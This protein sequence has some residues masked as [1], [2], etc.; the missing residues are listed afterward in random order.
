MRRSPILALSLLASGSL[1]LAACTQDFGIFGSTGG[2]GG[3]STS[4]TTTTTGGTG[5]CTANSDCND[6]NPCTDDTCDTAT[7][8]CN[9][10]D[11]AD[12]PV[13]GMPDTAGD[14]K[15]SQCT[16]GEVVTGPDDADVPSNMN[17]CVSVAC[18]NGN[19]DTTDVAAGTSCGPAPQQCDGMGQCVGCTMDN[20][21][22]AVG[23]CQQKNC[24]AMNVC[25]PTNKAAGATCS[26]NGGSACDGSGTCVECVDAGDCNGT[27]EIC[28]ATNQCVSSCG[29]TIENGNETDVDCGGPCPNDCG[30]GQK[31][32]NSGDC[33]SK[34]C[35][36]GGQK[37]CKAP[38]CNDNVQNGTETDQDC[39]GAGCPKCANGDTCLVN[40]DC[41]SAHCVGGTC[42]DACFD[43]VKDGT[44]TDVDCGGSCAANCALGKGCMAGNDCISTFCNVTTK[45]CVMQ[46]ADGAKQANEADIDCGGVCTTKCGDGKSCTAATDCTSGYCNSM[47]K[48]A[49]PT[50]T[51]TEKNGT[52]TDVDCGGNCT[53]KCADTNAC[54]VN[55]DC[56][57]NTCIGN[58]CYPAAC[59]NTTKDGAETDVDCGGGACPKCAN[60]LDCLVNADCT[61]NNCNNGTN[62]CM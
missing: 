19:V 5:G 51:D 16:A 34:V 25:S 54:L 56:V 49:T 3:T 7:G 60:G 39:G 57:N 33:V 24:D 45:L 29:D 31:C 37:T 8:K 18:N 55:A 32:N 10:A 28:S 40:G 1:V 38:A 26:S 14:C 47:M 42:V 12:G 27:T 13:P 36:G 9:N 30:T 2:S 35:T 61:N 11:V 17:P 53:T 4:S 41:L 23:D 59:K 21:C 43:L 62:K 46:C 22:P 15:M 58:V 52:E 20:D 50:C 44:E 48:C 6:T